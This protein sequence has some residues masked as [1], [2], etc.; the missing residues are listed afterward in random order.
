MLSIATNPFPP[1]ATVLSNL[2]ASKYSTP[3][4]S[5]SGSGSGILPDTWAKFKVS[6]NCFEFV[7]V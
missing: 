5:A 3:F 1:S 6:V 2:F 7:L 4:P